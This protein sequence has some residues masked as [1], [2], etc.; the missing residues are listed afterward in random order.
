MVSYLNLEKL[1]LLLW[2]PLRGDVFTALIDLRRCVDFVDFALLGISKEEGFVILI[3][4][5]FVAL[6][7]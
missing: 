7:A 4:L 6:S 5:L 1:L 3:M 2:M